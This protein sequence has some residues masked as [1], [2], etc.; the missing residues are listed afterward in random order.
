MMTLYEVIESL[1]NL[2]ARMQV[3]E[4]KYNLISEDFYGLAQARRLEQSKDSIKWL[5]YYELWLSRKELYRRLLAERIPL[6]A[7]EPVNIQALA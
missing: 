3:F 5:G 7:N 2:E 6:T 1:H 4:K